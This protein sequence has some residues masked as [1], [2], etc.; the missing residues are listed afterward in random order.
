MSE[1]QGPRASSGAKPLDPQTSCECVLDWHKC[2]SAR[3]QHAPNY[4]KISAEELAKY[5]KCRY[6]YKARKA[7]ALIV[8]T[9]CLCACAVRFNYIFHAVCYV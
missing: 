4:P 8:L 7:T 6:S 9:L 2:A 1:N 5:T 3:A